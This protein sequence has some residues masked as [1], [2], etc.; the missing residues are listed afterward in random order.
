MLIK[1]RVSLI[2]NTYFSDHL[3]QFSCSTFEYFIRISILLPPLSL[4]QFLSQQTKHEKP[5]QLL[6]CE[7]IDYP[8]VIYADHSIAVYLA[9]LIFILP[10]ITSK[11]I[12]I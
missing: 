6:I 7:Y 1:A 3:F 2:R 8:S 11:I 12:I 4:K 10:L 9:L 5:D